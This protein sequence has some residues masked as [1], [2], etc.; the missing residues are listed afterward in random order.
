MRE[1]AVG[2]SNRHIY[3]QT[4]MH[5]QLWN[6]SYE[7][8]RKDFHFLSNNLF[9]ALILLDVPRKCILYCTQTSM[10]RLIDSTL[11]VLWKGTENTNYIFFSQP[12]LTSKPK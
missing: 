2:I 9:H 4:H 8:V 3:N 1:T 12:M 6:G 7:Y 5:L 10:Q 11:V